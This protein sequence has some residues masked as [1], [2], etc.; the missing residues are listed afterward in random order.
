MDIGVI[1]TG[2]IASAV[3]QGL[4]GQGHRITVSERGREQS[5]RLAATIPE[6]TVAPNQAVLDASEV[7]FLGTTA[8][9]AP[10]VLE[11]LRFR[12]DQRVISLMVGLRAED[13]APL[14]SPARLE[15]QMIPFPAI[16]QGGSPILVYPAS[17]LVS[18]LFGDR[19]YLF[20]LDSAEALRGF[21][22]VQAVLSPSVKLLSDAAGWLVQRTGDAAQAERFLRVLVGGGL[23]ARPMDDD[24][25]LQDLIAALNTPGGLNA[26]LR[27]FMDER[28]MATALQDGLNQLEQR[29]KSEA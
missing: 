19:N 24:G 27:E 5:A 22:A 4:A 20:P 13:L 23:T 11:A 17:Q 3:V 18:A 14:V 15:T 12:P 6:V 28:G 16:A 10:A 29:L 1:G 25:V 7:V 8:Q 21:L 26:E 9:Q 2:T